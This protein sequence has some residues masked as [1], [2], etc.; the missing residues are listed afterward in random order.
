M[1]NSFW[2]KKTSSVFQEVIVVS[3]QPLVLWNMG[4]CA[5]RRKL[6]HL[7]ITSQKTQLHD[8]S[9]SFSLKHRPLPS[10]VRA[11]VSILC[12]CVCRCVSLC[13]CVSSRLPFSFKCT[14]VFGGP[15]LPPSF[16]HVFPHILPFPLPL[17]ARARRTPVEIPSTRVCLCN[18]RRGSPRHTLNRRPHAA[19]YSGGDGGVL[20]PDPTRPHPHPIP[21]R[22]VVC[23]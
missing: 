22:V 19:R 5:F 12:M 1:I 18:A 9:H 17:P 11:R 3:G 10:D 21:P 20:L 8:A 2:E 6:E 16:I 7:K 14:G 23:V 13:L 4:V 15:P